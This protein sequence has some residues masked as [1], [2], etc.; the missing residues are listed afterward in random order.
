[1]IFLR[2]SAAAARTDLNNEIGRR[3]ILR[4]G[5]GAGSRRYGDGP[6]VDGKIWLGSPNT[7]L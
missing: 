5:R 7:F 1:L 4:I 3:E 6:A 2:V